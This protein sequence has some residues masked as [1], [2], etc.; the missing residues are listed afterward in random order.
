MK[1][2]EPSIPIVILTA[3]CELDDKVTLSE[4]GADDYITKPLSP[5][6]LWRG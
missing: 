5:R 1:A 4:M 3:S 6:E 2:A